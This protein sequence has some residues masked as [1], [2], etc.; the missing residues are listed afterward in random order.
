M[1]KWGG[2][3]FNVTKIKPMHI[4]KIKL[5]KKP[6]TVSADNERRSP[7]L[8][9]CSFLAKMDFPSNL[10]WSD[11]QRWN[12]AVM[13]WMWLLGNWMNN[14]IVVRS[15]AMKNIKSNSAL[16]RLETHLKICTHESIKWESKVNISEAHQQTSLKS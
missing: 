9:K 4:K 2:N 11:L 8:F 14:T 13:L 16:K 10:S 3:I 5:K 1:T 7:N 12:L 15:W 6:I